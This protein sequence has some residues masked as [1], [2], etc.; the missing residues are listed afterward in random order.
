MTKV[1]KRLYRIE[2][3]RLAFLVDLL[4]SAAAAEHFIGGEWVDLIG[5]I[6]R[7]LVLFLTSG[8]SSCFTFDV[9]LE[10]ACSVI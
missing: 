5:R 9:C 4:I 8:L 6:V 10:N 3:F 1:S 7:V 2:N